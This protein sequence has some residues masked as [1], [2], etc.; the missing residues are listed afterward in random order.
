MKIHYLNFKN[1]FPN[2]NIEKKEDFY[3]IYVKNLNSIQIE[4]KITDRV[5]DKKQIK[6]N[7]SYGSLETQKSKSSVRKFFLD[8]YYK[9]F[10]ESKN[11]ALKKNLEYFSISIDK[12]I[13]YVDFNDKEEFIRIRSG[14]ND[15][16]LLGCLFFSIKFFTKKTISFRT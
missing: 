16:Y 8:Y 10:K 15:K 5:L 11:L 3:L 7:Y 6:I 12:E 13:I 1:K 2:I 4:K 9:N 14:L